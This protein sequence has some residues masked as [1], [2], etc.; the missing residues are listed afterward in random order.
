MEPRTIIIID[1]AASARALAADAVDLLAAEAGLSFTTIETS[2][3]RDGLQHLREQPPGSVALVVLDIH[4]P[5]ED[6]DGRMLASLIRQQFPTVPILLFTG[7]RDTQIGAQLRA[8]GFPEPVL[9]PVA[10][11]TLAEQMRAV[12]VA[13]PTS[14]D[15]PLQPL[16]AAQAHRMVRLL[17]NHVANRPVQLALFARHHLVL[18]GLQHILTVTEDTLPLEIVASGMSRDAIVAALQAG[19]VDL[20][21]AAPDAYEEAT[22]LAEQFRVPLLIYSTVEEARAI[23]AEPVSLVVGPASGPV[24]TAA[25]RTTLAGERYLEPHIEAALGLSARERTI[26]QLLMR[27]TPSA[28]IASALGLSDD[29]LRHVIG[30]LY[31]RL[32]VERQRSALAAWGHEARLDRFA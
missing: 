5:W 28:Q 7:D 22:L 24:L 27:G 20:L 14:N 3:G 9:K 21:L 19:R 6:V 12:M 25:L 2:T 15:V 17:E 30:G 29:R 32:G 10:P 26:M 31:E 18:A 8:L 16:L 11:E 4:L 1:D 13:P 23:I